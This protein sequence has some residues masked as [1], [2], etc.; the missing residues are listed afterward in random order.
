VVGLGCVNVA[1]KGVGMAE[2]DEGV[3]TLYSNRVGLSKGK[4]KWKVNECSPA[5]QFNREENCSI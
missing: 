3:N 5:T 4:K 2:S 1:T